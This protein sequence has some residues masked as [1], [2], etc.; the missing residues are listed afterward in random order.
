MKTFTDLGLE[1]GLVQSITTLGFTTPTPIQEQA[2]PVLLEGTKDFFGLAQT[3]TGKTASFG[4]PLLQLIDKKVNDIQALV[5]SP[6]RELCVQI[7]KDLQNYQKKYTPVHVVAVYGG[8]SITN[9][10]RKL[11]RGAHV[12]VATAGRL[13]DL[14]ERKAIDLN[15]IKYIVLD[16]ADEMLNMGFREDIELILTH[17]PRRDSMWL[18]SAT[19]SPDVRQVSKRFM[20]TPHEVSIGKQNTANAN[21]DHQ[22]FLCDHANRYEVLKRIIDFN[23]GMYGIIFAQ[24]KVDVQRVAENLTREGYE[25]EALHG[26]L[27]Q[28]QRDKVMA[29]FRQK[30]LQ[31]IVATDVAARGIDVQGITH[32]INFELPNDPEIYTHRCGRT[33]RAGST[34]ICLSLV[35]SKELFRFRR[36]EKM[37]QTT[38]HK[39]DIPS[40]KDICRKQFFHFIDKLLKVDVTHK[41]YATY[42]PT[43]QEKFADL[44]KEDILQRVAALEFDRFLQYYEN[45]IDLNVRN[46][47]AQD[48]RSTSGRYSEDSRSESRTAYSRSGNYKKLFINI[49]GV[50]GFHKASFLQFILDM[51]NLKKEVVGKI[52]IKDR[53][54]WVEIESGVANK[55]IQSLSG[56]KIKGRSIRVNYAD[57]RPS[58]S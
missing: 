19:M 39:I 50:D 28:N 47:N 1:D 31:L 11:H 18:F 45:S 55:M 48:R 58:T 6:T 57:S 4:L 16:E 53:N 21:I 43:L 22:Y 54:S 49:G 13:I 2:I 25:I 30:S 29:R 8:D 41:E 9:Q 37:L 24:T 7:T 34:G 3:G 38:I 12:V 36:I 44:T 20:K 35:T 46:N 17:T 14:I 52:D 42:L 26:D 10:I 32:V 5:V 51:S 33:G 23:V 15:K 40:G 56:K 27:N